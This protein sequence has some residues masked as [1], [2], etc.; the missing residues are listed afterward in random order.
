MRGEDPVRGPCP[1]APATCTWALI[2][3]ASARGTHPPQCWGCSHP[4]VGWCG[5]SECHVMT[6]GAQ[7]TLGPTDRWGALRARGW[8]GPGGSEP[9]ASCCGRAASSFS[10]R[11]QSAAQAQAGVLARRGAHG[12]RRQLG[13]R[14]PWRAPQDALRMRAAAFPGAPLLAGGARGGTRG[15]TRGLSGPRPSTLQGPL[16]PRAGAEQ[17]RETPRRPSRGWRALCLLPT[18]TLPVICPRPQGRMAQCSSPR[19][20]SFFNLSNYAEEP[21]D[22]KGESFDSIMWELA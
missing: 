15:G 17:P 18:P 5:S 3:S 2:H 4:R 12:A 1:R 8:A 21:A 9:S 10:S 11:S 14:S 6:P 20:K 16:P 19:I 13:A 7:S 22:R